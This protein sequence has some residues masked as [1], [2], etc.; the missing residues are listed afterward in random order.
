MYATV[1]DLVTGLEKIEGLLRVV[2]VSLCPAEGPDDFEKVDAAGVF[3]YTREAFERIDE[4]DSAIKK[5]VDLRR[6]HGLEAI[7]KR[8]VDVVLRLHLY[9]FKYDSIRSV[10]ELHREFLREAFVLGEVVDALGVLSWNDALRD[11]YVDVYRDVKKKFEL[12]F[13]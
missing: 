3:E 4:L 6:P 12:I 2:V 8:L 10:L 7:V 1:D 13:H 11:V 9:F 5:R